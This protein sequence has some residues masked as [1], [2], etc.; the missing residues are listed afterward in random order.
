MSVGEVEMEKHDI[1]KQ[2]IVVLVFLAI[3]V[4]LLGTFTILTEVNKVGSIGGPT[5]NAQGEVKLTI[6]DSNNIGTTT[7]SSTG[8]VLIDIVRKANG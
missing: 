3:L 8:E 4:S 2:T 1:S 6:V 7:S 5:N